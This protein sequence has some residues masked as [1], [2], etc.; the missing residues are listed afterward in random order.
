ACYFLSYAYTL[1]SPSARLVL[2]GGRRVCNVARSCSVERP[3]V[4]LLFLPRHRGRGLWRRGARL[5]LS[6]PRNEDA[7]EGQGPSPP[8]VLPDLHPH[9]RPAIPPGVLDELTARCPACSF[10]FFPAVAALGRSFSSRSASPP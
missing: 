3:N 9:A 1:M 6:H 8:P 2:A 7:R 10:A 4:P 5:R